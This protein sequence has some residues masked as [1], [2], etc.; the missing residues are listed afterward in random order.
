MKWE[1]LDSNYKSFDQINKGYESVIV[2][3]MSSKKYS[4]VGSFQE[5]ENK[6][7]KTNVGFFQFFYIN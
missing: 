7:K 2:D 4:E 6:K 3:Y 1:A 5:A